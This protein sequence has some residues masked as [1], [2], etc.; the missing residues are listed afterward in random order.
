MLKNYLEKAIQAHR[1]GKLSVAERGYR[2][3][4]KL[5]PSEPTALHMLGVVLLNTERTQDAFDVLTRAHNVSPQSV[6]VLYDLGMA[7]KAL[8]RLDDAMSYL[9]MAL[10]LNPKLHAAEFQIGLLYKTASN[11]RD[12]ESSFRRFIAQ[13][14]NQPHGYV[15]LGNVYREA[16]NLRAALPQYEKAAELAPSV[17][18]AH[19]NCGVTRADL[20]DFDG[21]IAALDRAI[22]LDRDN[23]QAWQARALAIRDRDGVAAGLKAIEESLAHK[24]DDVWAHLSKAEFLF[25][26]G[27]L[28]DAWAEYTWRTQAKSALANYRRRFGAR[29][30]GGASFA[31]R[32]VLLRAEQ[33]VGEQI[34]Y[35]SMIPDLLS[36]AESVTIECEPRLVPVFARSFPEAIV[37]AKDPPNADSPHTWSHDA[38]KPEIELPIGD[39]G[40]RFRDRMDRFPQHGGYLEVDGDRFQAMRTHYLDLAD[41]RPIVGVSWRSFNPLSAWRK[42]IPL[43]QWNSMLVQD[44]VFFVD[45]QYGNVDQER[46]T[47]EASGIKLYRDPMINP[48]IDLDGAAAQ[49]A[50]LDAV[51]STSNSGAHLAGGLNI[52][53]V[54]LLPARIERHWYWF[55]N[56]TPNPWY[57]SVR[58]VRQRKSADWTECLSDAESALADVL[59]LDH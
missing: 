30:W 10:K 20:G 45:I 13:L 35:A 29:D 7:S 31:D 59:S 32:H 16:G 5:N 55:P 9:A 50:A 51:V 58:V 27:A 40:T 3:A 48:S 43:D 8:H 52:P 23:M 33:G 25:E 47:A 24:Q 56:C 44:D 54:L 57:P 15:E 21:G 12:A 42:S 36:E 2:R 18:V 26:T 28:P 6:E 19:Q 53:T 17:S 34:L 22:A 37:L 4:L 14:P 1:Q 38:P 49:I 41:G 46:A 11:Y 39:L